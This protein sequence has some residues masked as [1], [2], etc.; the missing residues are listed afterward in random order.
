MHYNVVDYFLLISKQY[1]MNLLKMRVSQ[2][3]KGKI[4]LGSETFATFDHKGAERFQNEFL[5]STPMHC[6]SS[7]INMA[8]ILANNPISC[9]N[10]KKTTTFMHLLP[11][12]TLKI[13]T[14]MLPC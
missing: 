11:H 13:T 10:P 6:H 1:D 12:Q 7:L 9:P 3:R 5:A 4:T 8:N 14:C 2:G